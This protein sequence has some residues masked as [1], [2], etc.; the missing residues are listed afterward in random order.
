MTAS[1]VNALS[2]PK[3]LLQLSFL[4]MIAETV[5]AV[6]STGRRPLVFR[7]VKSFNGSTCCAIDTTSFTLPVDDIV[8]IPAGV[9][10]AVQCAYYCESL[11]G[12]GGCAGFNYLT[13]TPVRQCRFYNTAPNDCFATTSGCAY[14]EVRRQYCSV[15]KACMSKQAVW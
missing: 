12:T 11:N 13:Q 1:M 8:G 9:P 15:L 6:D 7:P 5:V 4:C 3:F 14:Y 10:G 2:V